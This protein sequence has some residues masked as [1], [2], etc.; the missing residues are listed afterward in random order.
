MASERR[1]VLITGGSGFVGASLA[2]A[3]VAAGDDVHLLVRRDS[4]LWR[5]AKIAGQF[6]AHQADLRDAR[7][8]RQ[9]V[10]DCQPEVIYH[11]AMYGGYPGQTE[12]TVTLETNVLGFAHL[13]EALESLDYRALINAGTSW[14]YGPRRGPIAETARLDPRTDYAVSKASAAMLCRAESLRGR[15][16]ATVRIFTTYGPRANPGMLIPYVMGCCLRGETPHVTSGGQCRDFVHVDD[17]VALLEAA[18]A[19]ARPEGPILHAGT[20]QARSVRSVVATILAVCGQAHVQAEFG[21]ESLR[22]DEPRGCVADIRRTTEI[23]GWRPRVDLRTG[24]QR[25]WASLRDG[26]GSRA[27]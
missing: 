3:R 25:T 20:G 26:G 6:A 27:A 9:A 18:V 15:P 21:A 14:E 1:R 16:V 8:V 13:L 2:L 4:N 22:P 24:L 7:G 5:L 10:L 17:V 23:T 12:R 11:L 19:V